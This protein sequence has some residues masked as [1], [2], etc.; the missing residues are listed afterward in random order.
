MNKVGF[1]FVAIK[2]PSGYFSHTDPQIGDIDPPL[3]FGSKN[4]KT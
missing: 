4:E 3:R 1:W 2:N